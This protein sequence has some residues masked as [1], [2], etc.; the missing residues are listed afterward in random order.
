[1]PAE[2]RKPG[3][4]AT[5]TS[6]LVLRLGWVRCAGSGGHRGVQVVS[7]AED[8]D[9]EAREHGAGRGG[10]PV[11]PCG[12]GG[13]CDRR[14]GPGRDGGQ[15]APQHRR[16]L[17]HEHISQHPPADAG[18]GAE[19]DG[20]GRPQSQAHRLAGPGDGEQAQAGGV[21]TVISGASP[22]S[23]LLSAN[24]ARPPAAATAR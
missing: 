24:A 12:D 17:P 23:W 2:T 22:A 5:G 9:E 20:R 14:G 15:P 3:R 10:Q 13:D 19:D 4:T 11:A 8:G 16:D 6:A 18:D 21:S 1:M 7:D